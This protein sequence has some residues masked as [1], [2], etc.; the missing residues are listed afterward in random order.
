M[1]GVKRIVCLLALGFLLVMLLPNFSHA[2]IHNV[3]IVDFQFIPQTDTVAVGDT[4]RWTN[5]GAVPH[6]STSNSGVWNSGTL[7]PGQSFSFQFNSTGTFPYHCAI[8]TSMTGTI[9]VRHAMPIL[10]GWGVL[11]L[12]LLL[13]S[14]GIWVWKRRRSTIA[15]RAD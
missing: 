5:N 9:I 13:L 14:S 6:T 15:V 10:T 11:V 3:S 4:V 8:H 2:T 12:V 1:F 7:S